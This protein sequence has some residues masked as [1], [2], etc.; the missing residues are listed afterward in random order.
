MNVDTTL[1]TIYNHIQNI[2]IE[3]FSTAASNLTTAFTVLK[4]NI[5]NLTTELKMGNTWDDE[6]I[7]ETT[8][9]T[10]ITLTSLI[11]SCQKPIE[12]VI[13]HTGPLI[14]DLKTAIEKHIEA[15]ENYNLTDEKLKLRKRNEPN[16]SDYGTDEAS[17]NSDYGSWKRSCERLE[18]QK[19]TYKEDAE[20]W[21]IYANQKK[22][23]LVNMLVPGGSYKGA[24][25]VTMAG[26]NVTEFEETTPNGYIKRGTRITDENGNVIEEEYE[27]YNEG[28]LLQSGKLIYN[29]DNTMTE[30][31]ISYTEQATRS[32]TIY[33][34]ADRK[35][36]KEIYEAEL[37]NGQT[38]EGTRVYESDRSSVETYVLKEGDKEVDGG[39]RRYNAEG[40]LIREWGDGENSGNGVG[41]DD[42]AQQEEPPGVY[43]YKEMT[44][45]TKEEFAEYLSSVSR[46]QL[47][48]EQAMSSVDNMIENNQATF[49]ETTQEPVAPTT[50]DQATTTPLE[51]R[52]IV[53]G[54]SAN[55][56][57]TAIYNCYKKSPYSD[58]TRASLT[59]Q[60]I[61][62]LNRTGT[63]KIYGTT[64]ELTGDSTNGYSLVEVME[65][66]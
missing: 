18:T 37:S 63:C 30:S 44:F 38:Q 51:P 55:D 64:Y 54:V 8:G 14:E 53:S 9:D 21:Q 6:V 24:L 62:E 52:T 39:S 31:Y 46:G 29:D 16:K 27:V 5:D 26:V 66:N 50:I 19:Q 1:E 15:V 60:A 4:T 34:D 36:T 13:T 12:N 2:T 47:T 48:P 40:E 3:K 11:D 61:D 32:G 23:L 57:G 10:S 28:T 45:E 65:Y 33:Y 7:V 43:K 20:Y 22:A 42:Y 49:V 25:T 59:K 35:P 17:Y 56:L 41:R 58:T